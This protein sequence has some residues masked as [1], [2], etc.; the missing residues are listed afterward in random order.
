MHST[1]VSN[2]GILAIG[3][4]VFD[5]QANQEQVAKLRSSGGGCSAWKDLHF[6]PLPASRREIEE[7]SSVWQHS[8]GEYPVLRYSG[9][10]AT[11]N[12]FLR[13]ASG[14]HQLH[15]ATHA[16]FIPQDCGDSN[17]LLRAGLAFSGAN[18]SASG[19]RQGIVTA[20]E[21]AG[22]DLSGT[23]WAV[24]SACN[25]GNGEVRDGEGVL[26][27]Q[28]AFRLAGVETIVMSLWSVDDESTREFMRQL[29]ALRLQHRASTADAIRAGTRQQLQ[30]RRAAGKSTHPFYWAAF[31]ASGNWQ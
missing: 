9:A 14:K 25:T 19:E 15:I 16:Y 26:G 31:I 27:L 8:G 28:R 24:L 10:D 2:S 3:A 1:A 12:A 23:R 17:P 29:Y 7:V 20:Q 4:P 13:E 30:T 6:D 5:A 21:I 18:L 11:R 22:M